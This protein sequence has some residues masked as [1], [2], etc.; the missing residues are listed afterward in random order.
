MILP[1]RLLLTLLIWF[2]ACANLP[3]AQ[4]PPAPAPVSTVSL[5]PP[6]ASLVSPTVPPR[7]LRLWLPPQ[8][9]PNGDAPAAR[10][11]QARLAGFSARHPEIR[12]DIR[13]KNNLLENLALTR[14][15]APDVLPDLVALSHAEMEAAVMKGYIHPLSGLTDLPY[16]P[17]WYPYARQ[18][19]LIQNTP[20]GLA[21]A[22]DALVLVYRPSQFSHP[23]ADWP[24]LFAQSAPL[25]LAGSDPN[26]LFSLNLYL[27]LGGKLFNDHNHPT[28]DK[29]PLTNLLSFFATGGENHVFSKDSLA[30]SSE[31]EVW[32]AFR[33]GEAHVAV[34]WLSQFLQMP[35]EDAAILPLSG[36]DGAPHTLADGWMWT[37]AG[38]QPEN[39]P[40]AV[41]LA[42]WLMDETYLA[43]WVDAAGYL[44]TRPTLLAKRGDQSLRPLLE[45]VA[46]SAQSVPSAELSQALGPPLQG[47]V[48]RLFNGAPLDV[49]VEETLQQLH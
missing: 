49:V 33:R 41:E 11:L 37:L 45:V 29:E 48:N 23:P 26:A 44:P 14:A 10:L 38:A 4:T 2:T 40:L 39:Q 12:L 19:G 1:R 27:S 17:D 35:L 13:L 24:T 9:D 43:G 32:Q 15:A 31:E 42:A 30:Y 3:S 21:F 7:W 18:L 20:Y 22:G 25:A 28:L 16:S 8:F 5:S 46:G 36:L 6:A 34:I 47:A